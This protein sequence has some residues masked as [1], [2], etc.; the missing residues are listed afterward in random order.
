MR[1]IKIFLSY[2]HADFEVAQDLRRRLEPHLAIAK[3]FQVELWQD[4]D[5]LPGQVWFKKIME[6]LDQADAGLLLV[7]PSFLGSAFISGEELPALVAPGKIL[8][9]VLLKPVD[10]GRTDMKGLEQYQIF[11]GGQPQHC[12]AFTQMNRDEFAMQAFRKIYDRLVKEMGN[13]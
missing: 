5:L 9:P 11:G 8:L 13:G 1:P 2:A 6:A 4:V 10:F 3:G 12:R 7:S